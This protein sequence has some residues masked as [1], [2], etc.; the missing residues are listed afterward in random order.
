MFDKLFECSCK[1]NLSGLESQLKDLLERTWNLLSEDFCMSVLSRNS[2]I[3]E[4]NRNDLARVEV[5]ADD[6][7][8]VVFCNMGI[9]ETTIPQLYEAWFDLPV[10]KQDKLLIETFPSNRVYGV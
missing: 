9:W 3:C 10:E 7:R 5:S 8:S 4:V 1:V 6:V 2:S